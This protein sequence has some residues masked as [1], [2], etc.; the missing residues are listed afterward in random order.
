M[1]LQSHPDRVYTIRWFHCKVQSHGLHPPESRHLGIIRRAK[2]CR[3][4]YLRMGKG[5]ARLGVGTI[6]PRCQLKGGTS[7]AKTAR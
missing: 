6:R 1:L 3:E 7:N 2:G 4:H 5:E